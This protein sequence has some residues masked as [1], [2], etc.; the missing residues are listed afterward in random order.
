MK[1]RQKQTR[2]GTIVI[3]AA[4]LAIV[5]LAMVAFSVDV[6]YVLTAK[7]ELQRTA[8]ASALAA[9]WDYGKSLSQGQTYTTASQTGRTTASNYASYNKVTKNPAQIDTNT[10]NSPSG[11]VV[12]GYI[13][14]LGGSA[15]NF[16]TGTTANY[17]AVQVRVRKDTTH[18]R[19]GALFLCPHLRHA[20]TSPQAQATAALVR[21]VSGFEA[22]ADGSNLDLLPFA[23]DLQTWNSLMAGSGDDAWRWDPV[24]KKV[25]AGSDGVLEVNL[26]PQGTGSPGNRGTVD[27]GSSNNS[28]ADIARQI[29][30]G[31]SASRSLLSR[32]QDPIR[33]QRRAAAQR[34]H[35]HQRRRQRRARLD[36]RQAPRD[37]D[38][39]QSSRT[40]QQR[41]IHDRQM[42]R[43]PHHGRPAHRRDE[44][45]ARHDPSSAD[46]R[47][48][49]IAECDN[50]HER[51]RLFASRA[52]EIAGRATVWIGDHI[53]ET[54]RKSRGLIHTLQPM[55]NPHRP[56]RKPSAIATGQSIAN[57]CGAAAVEFAIVAPVFFLLVIG[58][59][60]IGR[61]LMV[62]QVLI[63]AS[64]VGARQAVN[65]RGYDFSRADR[66]KDYATSVAVP[67]VSVS[68]EP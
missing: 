38:L 62:Q 7:E 43:H 20:G 13:S 59:I 34:R 21:D 26:Y 9:C 63:N 5:L 35:R 18:Q 56:T 22:P 12:F 15:N 2:R 50:W 36:H 58:M 66:C 10:S 52:R 24:N 60:E 27:I 47:T 64:R 39:L 67:S 25:V 49:H 44:Q 61:A 28:T 19:Q 54:I 41:P 8:D 23:L 30:Y 53:Y 29:V 11:D 55:C 45:E 42:V 14:D 32:R 37:P 65:G 57:R 46:N 31:V 48:R 68:V 1:R 3:M 51:L 17:N 16:Q 4:V 40:G 33:R 6:G